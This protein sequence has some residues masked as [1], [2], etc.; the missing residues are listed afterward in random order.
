[1]DGRA[2]ALVCIAPADISAHRII[3]VLVG[4]F[5]VVAQQTDRCHDLPGL[6]IAALWHIEFRPG[7]LDSLGNFSGNTFDGQDVAAYDIRNA[8]LTGARR[9][10]IDMDRACATQRLATSVLRADESQV[11]SKYPK[12][13]LLG[14]NVNIS[15]LSIERNAHLDSPTIDY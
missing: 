1:M 10:P 11:V 8:G 5:A 12:Q 7:R 3:D 15:R 2:D 6:A 13:R 9:L 4:R 14:I